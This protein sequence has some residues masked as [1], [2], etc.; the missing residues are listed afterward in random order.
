MRRLLPFFLLPMLGFGQRFRADDPLER[1]PPPRNVENALSRK[2]SDYYDLFSNQFGNTGERQPKQGAPRTALAVNTLGEP[3]ESGWYEKRH[4]YRQMSLEE[5]ARGPGR[6]TPPSTKGKWTVVSAKSEGITPGFVILDPDKRRYFVKFDP[7][8]NPEM[9]TAAD[10]ISSRFFHALGYF[11]PDNYIVYFTADQLQIGEK[12]LLSDK[13][14][15]RRKMEPGDI[16]EILKSVPRTKDGKYRAT[17][18]L[19]I[20]GKVIGPPRYFGTRTD[21][22]NDV[23][24]HEHRRDLRGLHVFCAWLGHDDSRSINNIDVVA[25]ENG[26]QFVKHFLLDFGST[27]GSA[28]SKPNSPRSGDYFF[29]W[30]SSAKQFFTLGL[31]PPYWAFA[32]Y[33]DYPAVGRFEWKTFDPEKWVPE[34]PNPA[35]LN[36]L[37]DDE[38]WGAK[39]VVA[40]R[41][42]EIAAIV[43]TG[44]ISDPK[45]A[46]YMAQCLRERRNKIGKIYFSKV[47][48][49]DQFRVENG[50]LVWVDLGAKYRGEPIG[51]IV[52]QWSRYDNRS[53]AMTPLASA[54]SVRVPAG[55]G[56]F[57]AARLSTPA[58]PKQS[59]TVFLRV[60]GGTPTVVG[61]DRQWQ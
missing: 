14:G 16:Q 44:E 8:S 10:A 53:G 47:L 60:S 17:A 9:A 56:E 21:D 36:R 42:E 35:F 43:A 54:S 57:V 25:S 31:Q 38:F 12:V 50:Q 22:P 55:E 5:L 20:S 59:V 1:E 4:Y 58:R 30:K 61:I 48:P 29:S 3:M 45:A 18:S 19:A 2:F 13:T 49:F 46:A 33:P 34:Y 11:V 37:P 27:L 26:V 23:T 52:T 51:D 41:D 15:R 7:M 6:G 40:F 24:P 28:S 39:Q 32:H